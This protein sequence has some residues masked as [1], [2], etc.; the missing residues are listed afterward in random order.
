METLSEAL[1]AAIRASG[2]GVNELGD[3]AG[4]G[5]GIV[6]RFVR[7]ERSVTLRVADRIAA[8][9]GLVLVKQPE[10]GRPSTRAPRRGIGVGSKRTT[11]P[12]RTGKAARGKK[13]D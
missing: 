4:V 3:A 8:E 7:G 10:R 13:G 1:R 11:Q 6:S 12:A 9:L 5:G 2:R